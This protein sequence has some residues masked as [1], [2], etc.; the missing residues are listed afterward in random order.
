MNTE[1]QTVEI[2][3]PH[4]IHFIEK[5]REF[6]DYT[7][8]QGDQFITRV[9]ILADDARQINHVCGKWRGYK[10]DFCSLFFG[11]GYDFHFA[12]FRLWN[13]GMPGFKEFLDIDERDRLFESPPLPYEY[14]R[15]LLL[16][17]N[18]HAI[19]DDFPGGYKPVKLPSFKQCYGN[20]KNWGKFILSRP[21]AEQKEIISDILTNYKG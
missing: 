17:F 18:N 4:I 16:Y 8:S 3:F 7:L 6:E 13:I 12:C 15:L 11:T 14:Y 21:K 5:Y 19:S 2:P 20:S 10:K 9:L 1:T